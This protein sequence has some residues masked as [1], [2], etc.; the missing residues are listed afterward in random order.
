[1]SQGR[2]SRRVRSAAARKATTRKVRPARRKEPAAAQVL[3][4]G[5]LGTAIEMALDRR[6]RKKGY[7]F[8]P[9]EA[10]RVCRFVGLCK[11]SKGKWA[12]QPLK[13]EPWQRRI[14][15]RLFGWRR[16][17]G[18][19]RYRRAALWLPRKNGK[20]T[21][22]AVLLLYLTAADGE[23]G[24]QVFS[25]ASN[26]EQAGMVFDE[27]KLMVQASRELSATSALYKST[28]F[29]PQKKGVYRVL[30]AKPGSKHGLNVHG[31]GID[32]IHAI[33]DR[34]L[35]DVLTSASASRTQPMEIV[36]ST[37]G[38]NIGSFG[39]EIWEYAL[40]V[41]DG[42]LEDPEFL[43]V[44]YAADPGDDWRSEKTW[45]KANP[46]YGV[47]VS[48]DFLRGELTKTRGMPGRIAAFKQLYLNLWTQ[49]AE[50]WLPIDK[51]RDCFAGARA[52]SA[53]KGRRCWAGLDLSSTTDLTALAL[54]FEPG[55]DEVY[56]LA[57]FFW[58]PRDTALEHERA[59]RA[60][61]VKWIDQRFLRA[62]PGNVV[63]YDLVERDVAKIAGFVQ[64]QELAY[65]RWGASQ[66]SQRLQDVHGITMVQHGQGYKDMSPAAKEFE[67]VVLSKKV[68]IHEN[69][70]LLWQLSNVIVKRDPSGNIKPDKSRPT[71]RIDGVVAALMALARASL[72]EQ[73]TSVY[74]RRGVITA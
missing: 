16:E 12:G 7:W 54:V 63:D 47:S 4:E 18:T 69:P 38:N 3:D 28:I 23:N 65:D 39:Y 53:Y 67:R 55:E 11:H 43:A 30:S 56:D 71:N 19:R 27:A 72:R 5:E 61:Y 64:L 1:M 52:L 6:L 25:A 70:V 62:T 13:L 36:I 21:L 58:V 17:D 8:D 15:R 42:V 49:A 60:Q 10:D 37:A 45:E 29:F 34:E 9:A 41:R 57:V 59:D 32:E 68:R 74:S 50:A 66:I 44:V 24:A 26:R 31:V 51:C 20:S 46:N 33:K 14:V 40:K 35:Y 73:N 48:P 2:P 22:I